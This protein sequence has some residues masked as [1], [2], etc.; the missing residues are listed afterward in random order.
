MDICADPYKGVVTRVWKL[1]SS[2]FLASPDI[3]RTISFSCMQN[4]VQLSKEYRLTANLLTDTQTDKTDYRVSNAFD[5]QYLV[6][7]YWDTL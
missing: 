5:R 7:L 6:I 1:P 2:F 4:F 3:E